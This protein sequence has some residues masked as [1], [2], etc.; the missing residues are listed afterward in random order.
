M[1]RRDDTHPDYHHFQNTNAESDRALE[2]VRFLRA[3]LRNKEAKRS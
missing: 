1:K 2:G 3:P